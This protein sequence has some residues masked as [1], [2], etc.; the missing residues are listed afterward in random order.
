MDMR[1]CSECK[2]WKPATT[3][4]FSRRTERKSGLNTRCKLC[5]KK[6]YQNNKEKIKSYQQK[7]KE[8][9]VEYRRKYNEEHKEELAK[10]RKKYNNEH[11]EELN[12][13]ARIFRQEH[14]EEQRI[15]GREY[16]KKRK[17]KRRQYRFN[18]IDKWRKYKHDRRARE[19]S[20]EGTYTLAEIQKIWELQAGK[21]LYCGSILDKVELDHFIPL[22][23]GGKNDKTN[24]V[25][26]CVFCNR[27]KNSKMPWNWSGW[28]CVA[29]VFW[30]GIVQ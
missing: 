22:K 30:E 4:Y 12:R 21:C 24:L 18:N 28:N 7:H 17:E 15:K 20:A 10:K 11:R 6:Y 1:Q 5:S 19:L 14:L 3:E 2:E 13:K 27:S 23:Y 16:D 9:F 8:Y 26:S 25:W 29:P